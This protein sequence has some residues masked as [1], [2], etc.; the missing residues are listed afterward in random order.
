MATRYQ[1]S[2]TCENGRGVVL[3]YISAHTPPFCPESVCI[4][5]EYYHVAGLGEYFAE[6][7]EIGIK[8][9]K[10]GITDSLDSLTRIVKHHCDNGASI[11]LNTGID[12][13]FS[14]V[15]TNCQDVID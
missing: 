2:L 4:H 12:F 1:I 9:N 7:N 11:I 5:D 8:L 14:N 13:D 10:N 3:E 15:G 6:T